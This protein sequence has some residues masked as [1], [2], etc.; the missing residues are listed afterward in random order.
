[1]PAL[2]QVE[3]KHCVAGLQECEIDG[4][5]CLGTRMWLNI[6]VIGTEDLLRAIDG[7]LLDLVDE[8]AA[9]VI[10]LSGKAFGILVR[11]WR[12][13]RLEHRLGNEI[14]ARDELDAVTL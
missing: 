13:H 1:M 6:R 8:L 2:R 11:E 10:P 7:E 5:V 9:A 4:R 14:F 12:A 3:S